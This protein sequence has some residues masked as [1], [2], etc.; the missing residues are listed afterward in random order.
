MD[1]E[2]P[3]KAGE[4][5]KPSLSLSL[6]GPLEP[7]VPEVTLEELI[8][9]NAE[10]EMEDEVEMGS[11]I[12]VLPDE[13]KLE[14]AGDGS[15]PLRLLFCGHV[16]HKTCVDPWLTDVSGR[17]PVCQRP[18]EFPVHSNKKKRRTRRSR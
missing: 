16:F 17:C 10:E 13:L 15:Q 4:K 14:D 18:V 6:P 7:T 12:D 1:F 11:D 5:A 8:Q 9:Q 3:P 2:E